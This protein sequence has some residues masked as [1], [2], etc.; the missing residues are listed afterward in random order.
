MDN[1]LI[2]KQQEEIDE[3]KE[4][5]TALEKENDRLGDAINEAKYYLNNV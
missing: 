1:K 3:L 5:I 4:R 2:E